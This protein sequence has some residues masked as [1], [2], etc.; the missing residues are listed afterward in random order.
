MTEKD[1][2]KK[3]GISGDLS[4][5]IVMADIDKSDDDKKAKKGK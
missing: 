4:I 5:K 3:Y 2:F 1:F